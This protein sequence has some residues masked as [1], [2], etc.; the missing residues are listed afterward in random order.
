MMLK[1]GDLIDFPSSPGQTVRIIWLSQQHDTVTICRV[2]QANAFPERAPAQPLIEMLS[3]GEAVLMEHDP[4]LPT[5]AEAALSASRKRVRDRAW[6][7]IKPLV[8]NV[9]NIFSEERRGKLIQDLVEAARNGKNPNVK[10]TTKK[11]IY[12]Y[13]R[14][15][16]QRGMVPNA[17]LADYQNSGAKGKARK[18]SKKKRGRPRK[19]GHATGT[20]VTENIRKIF[21]VG[22]SRCYASDRQKKWSLKDAYHKIAEDFFCDKIIDSETGN[23]THVTSEDARQAGGVPTFEQFKYWSDKDHVRLDVKRKRLGARVYDKDFRGLIG[24]SNAEVMGPGDRYQIDATIADVY[25]VSRLN[26]HRIIGRPVIYVVID[27]FSRMIVG[28]YVGLEGPSWVTAMM[29]LANTAA[30]KVEYCKKFGIDIEPEDWPCHFLPG[31]LLGDRGEIESAKIDALIN[32]FNVSVENAAAYRADWK[33]IIEQH[34]N[35]LPAMFKPYVPGYIEQD[36]R[37]R[38]GK[39]YRLDAVLDIDE[40]TRIVIE[41]TLY[42][43]NHKEITKYDKD[44][45]VKADGVPPIPV[46]LWGWGRTYRTG[47]MRS[48]PQDFVEFSLMPTD[49]AVV[50]TFGIRHMGSFYTCA[51]AMEERWFDQARQNGIWEVNVSYD[52]RNLDT[53]YLHGTGSSNPFQ[54]CAL[55]DRSRAHRNASLWEIE[56]QN[57]LDKHGAANRQESRQLARVDLNASIEKTVAEALHKRGKPSTDSDANRTKNIQ[58]NRAEEKQA[59]RETEVFR[60][61]QKKLTGEG[62]SA[63]IIEF[64]GSKS[65]GVADYSMPSIEEILGEDDE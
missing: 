21:R 55:T 44:R 7:L 42:K 23:V 24:T 46:E 30:D 12:G 37:A 32:N 6:A 64:P 13:L 15:F 1:I 47:A 59:N 38:G 62:A 51:Q 57:E 31:V 11:S 43:N 14:R 53:I 65:D 45:D 5:V 60:P 16:W 2:N 4:Y 19:Y 28:L 39:D 18:A 48:F 50:T 26:R 34:F 10:K 40:F 8:E 25:L 41:C 9:P 49:K 36:F 58:G 63:K 22:F 20:N 61:G 3:K 35:L 29:A 54:T 56:Q 52:P 17:V 33:G 27:V